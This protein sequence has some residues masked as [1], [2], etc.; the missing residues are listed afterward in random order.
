MVELTRNA[1]AGE[2]PAWDLFV[3]TMDIDK[4]NDY[5]FDPLDATKTWPEDRFPL[6]PVGKMVLDRNVDNWFT[7]NEMVSV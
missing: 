5:E 3:Q 2:F 1:V 7:D 6:R 4:E